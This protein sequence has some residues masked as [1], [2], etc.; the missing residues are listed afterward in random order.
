M[1]TGPAAIALQGTST[2]LSIYGS[3]KA[4]AD[5]RKA[6]AAS[7]KYYY[8]VADL[9]EES[10]RADIESGMNEITD[11]DKAEKAMES[12]Q[13]AVMAAS[14]VGAGSVTAEDILKDTVNRATMDE[15]TIRFNANSAAKSKIAQ[16][17]SYRVAGDNAVAAGDINANTTLIT[18]ATGVANNWLNFGNSRGWFQ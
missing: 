9:T 12:R 11:I 4:A 6:A 18:G 14:G 15:M 1:C 16:A 3:L 13:R 17:K 7:K 5:Q 2:G 10:A 8:Y